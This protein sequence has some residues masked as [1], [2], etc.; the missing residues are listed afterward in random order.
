MLARLSHFAATAPIG[1]C[2]A[3]AASLALALTLGVY[4]YSLPHH[5]YRHQRAQ[6]ALAKH[7]DTSQ[8][9][10]GILTAI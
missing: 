1:L 4:A 8:P 5:H 3:L 6:Y 2:L 10:R 7:G 9:V